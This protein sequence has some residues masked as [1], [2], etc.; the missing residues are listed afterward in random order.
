[1]AGFGG[2]RDHDGRPRFAPRLPAGWTR[3]RFQVQLQGQRLEVDMTPGDT[4]YTL[5]EGDGLTI[6]HFGQTL[7]VSPGGYGEE[8]AA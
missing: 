1:M 6:S 5:L 2:L 8:L 3:L 4:N 7:H